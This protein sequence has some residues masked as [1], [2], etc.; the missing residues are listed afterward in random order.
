[1]GALE[2]RDGSV[3]TPTTTSAPDIVAALTVNQLFDSVALSVDGPNAWNEHLTIDW[4]IS[5]H[6]THRSTLSNGVLIH[7]DVELDTSGA[8]TTFTRI[9]AVAW[10]R[11]V[12]VSQ[13]SPEGSQQCLAGDV[14]QFVAEEASLV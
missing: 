3:G 6:G 4:N 8:D 2:L 5:G 12:L 7:H 1:M 10:S 9:A 13:P 14:E 11:E